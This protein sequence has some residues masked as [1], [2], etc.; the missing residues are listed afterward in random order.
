MSQRTAI[1]VAC[2]TVALLAVI[3]LRHRLRKIDEFVESVRHLPSATGSDLLE[4]ALRRDSGFYW[5]RLLVGTLIHL[6]ALLSLVLIIGISTARISPT[7]STAG[8]SGL[9]ALAGGAVIAFPLAGYV[10]GR[11]SRSASKVEPVTS[12]AFAAILVATL[13]GR[14]DLGLGIVA[15]I[16]TPFAIVLSALGTWLGAP[17]A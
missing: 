17:R 15:M 6:G 11:T 10:L 2:A 7:P 4:H 16:M 8:E 9:V 14:L 1:L 12:A 3:A 13:V 5:G